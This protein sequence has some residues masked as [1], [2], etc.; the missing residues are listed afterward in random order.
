[1]D[2]ELVM[3]DLLEVK[4]VGVGE[5]AIHHYGKILQAVVAMEEMAELSKEISKAIRKNFELGNESIA[6]E[7]ADVEIML[8][9]LKQIF[10]CHDAVKLWTVNKLD[11]TFNRI[12]AELG[13]SN[14]KPGAND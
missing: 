9:Q 4:K 10:M 11:R 13:E 14:G 5:L 3:K 7:I 8:E 12:K 1:M 2:K 6:E